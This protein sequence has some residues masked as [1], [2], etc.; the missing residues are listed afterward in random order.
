MVFR[1]GTLLPIVAWLSTWPGMECLRAQE[2]TAVS[3]EVVPLTLPALVGI[4]ACPLLGLRIKA[5]ETGQPVSLTGIDVALDGTT[6]PADL[7]QLQVYSSGPSG[8]F[9]K[10]VPVG[11][12]SAPGDPLDPEIR[13]ELAA[14]TNHFWIACELDAKADIDHRVGAVCREVRFSDGSKV[15]P[16]GAPALQRMGIAV[17][18]AGDDGVHTFRIP[19]LVTTLRGT[20]I[21]VYDVRR[22]GPGDLPG[23]IDVGLSR[24]TDGGRTW[25]PMKI[26]LDMGADP[27]FRFDG[28]GDPAVLADRISGTIWVA[29][30]WSHGNRSWTGSQ[31]GL[32]PDETGQWMLVRSDDD[33]LSWSDPVNITEQVKR[34]EWSLML[35]GPGCGIT[36]RDGTLVF[37]AQYQDP[38]HPEN[39]AAHRL[40]HSTFIYSR[41]RGRSWQTATGAFEDTTEA[42]LVELADGEIM[43]NCRYNREANR[44]VMTT[45]DMG[46]T[47]RE[48]PT[49]RGGLVEPRACMASLIHVDGDSGDR[50]SGWLLFSN[51]DSPDIRH[52]LTV[53]GSPDLGRTW[54]EKNRILLD[55]G[56]SRGYSC[57]TLV[58]RDTVGILYEG[59]RSDLV[60][61]RIPFREI[62]DGGR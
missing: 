5:A 54:P 58:D 17:R 53:K 52:R 48:H 55:E 59:S 23:D 31:P 6:D 47:W 42:Q 20:L 35:Q 45:T 16:R 14:G 28:V 50:G 9:S 2:G 32:K 61:Q 25:E 41:D 46:Q 57:L 12:P 21:A 27:E 13:C 15:P 22:S 8:D 39:P 29:A 60:F 26:I 38:P 36:L 51:P 56:T 37:P 30:V 10:A 11:K 33:G 40:P 24:S 43:I 34:P 1:F 44:V 49:S 19:G 7:R 4:R 3:V 62:V 18:R